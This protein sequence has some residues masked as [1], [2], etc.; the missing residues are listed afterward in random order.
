MCS[1]AVLNVLGA[2]TPEIYCLLLRTTKH[3]FGVFHGCTKFV[4]YFRKEKKK[5]GK[6]LQMEEAVIPK[7][8][9]LLRYEFWQQ[10][11]AGYKGP[12]TLRFHIYVIPEGTMLKDMVAY[13]FKNPVGRMVEFAKVKAGKRRDGK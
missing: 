12:H 1:T 9:V 6:E 7:Y 2:G 4:H 13:S 10:N 8:S 5:L 3:H 11:G